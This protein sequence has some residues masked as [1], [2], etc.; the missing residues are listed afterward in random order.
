MTDISH[1]AQRLGLLT[2]SVAHIVYGGSARAWES[3]RAQLWA[4]TA[5][6]FD[7]QV[8]GAR[9]FGHDNE[10]K[11][12][13][14]FW[15]RHPEVKSIS[16]GGFFLME[17]DGPLKGWVGSSPDRR[18]MVGRK[19]F[20][21]EIKSP[22]REEMMSKHGLKKHRHQCQHGMLC[23]GWKKWYL[24]SHCG[25]QYHEDL[26]LPDKAWQSTYLQRALLFKE[27]CYDGRQVARR[28]LSIT[29]IE[30]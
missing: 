17:T 10:D 23:T 8:G 2:S 9:E 4:A 29:D 22:T 20:G 27:F 1:G 26:L 30:D 19:M 25:E 21:L 5:E 24:V 7:Q 14:M 13:S 6:D 18:I 15:E 12:A 3:L 28:K 16:A 11:G